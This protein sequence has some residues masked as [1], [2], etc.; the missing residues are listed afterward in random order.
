MNTT[1][2]TN[3][4]NFLIHIK[5][6]KGSKYFKAPS[7]IAIVISSEKDLFIILNLRSFL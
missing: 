5:T 6:T 2:P 1:T 7:K 3:S 4:I